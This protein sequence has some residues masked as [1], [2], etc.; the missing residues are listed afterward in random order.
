[1]GNPPPK[2]SGRVGEGRLLQKLREASGPPHK[3]ADG[4]VLSMLCTD[5]RASV[6]GVTLTV[7]F[8]NCFVFCTCRSFRN[9]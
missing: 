3:A 5:L 7:C 4:P 2:R 6:S 8:L 1:M 9:P